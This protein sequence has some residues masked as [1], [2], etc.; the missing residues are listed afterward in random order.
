M[1]QPEERLRPPPN[2]RHTGPVVPLD[3]AATAR[4]LR[5][6]AHAAQDGHRQIGLVHRGSVRLLVFA[7]DAGGQLRDHH[8][9]GYVVIQT[10]SGRLQVR[11]PAGVQDLGAGQAVLLDPGVPHSVQAL[12]ASDMLLSLFLERPPTGA[13]AA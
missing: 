13:P 11:T 2:A 6:E 4:A 5:A 7:F 12:E 9:P 10:L 8:A 1:T 3:F